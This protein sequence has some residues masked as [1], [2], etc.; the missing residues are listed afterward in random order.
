MLPHPLPLSFLYP[1]KQHPVFTAEKINN[2]AEVTCEPPEIRVGFCVCVFPR[3][4]DP[5]F[6]SLSAEGPVTKK[7]FESPLQGYS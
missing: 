5:Q 4:E 7:G 6:F 3:G 1:Q 2:T